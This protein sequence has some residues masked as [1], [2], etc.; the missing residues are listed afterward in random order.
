MTG[1]PPLVPFEGEWS[2][3]EERVYQAFL[4]TFVRGSVHFRGQ[5]VS[6]PVRPEFRGKGRSFWHVISTAPEQGN[7]EE[8]DRIPDLRRCERIRWIAWAVEA[9]SAEAEG[10]VWWENRRSSETCV[11]IWSEAQDYAVVLGKR[12]GYFVLKTAY[13]GIKPNQRRAFIR[14]RQAFAGGQKS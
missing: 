4:E 7:R 9:A 3:Y 11:V 5:R 13:S 8:E 1:P 10:V 14:E 2:E 6:A 12:D